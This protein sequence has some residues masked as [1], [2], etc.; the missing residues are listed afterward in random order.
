MPDWDAILDEAKAGALEALEVELAE[1]MAVGEES[2]R[3]LARVAEV[4]VE[5]WRAVNGPEGVEQIYAEFLLEDARAAIV[6]IQRRHSISTK[7][8]AQKSVQRIL[9]EVARIGARLLGA[10]LKAAA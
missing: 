4:L 3:E 7:R 9:G 5:Y 2:R 1:W 6:I 10:L 8:A